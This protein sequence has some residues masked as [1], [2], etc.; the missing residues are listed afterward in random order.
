MDELIE[1]LERWVIGREPAREVGGAR[2][3]PAHSLHDPRV[4]NFDQIVELEPMDSNL[5]GSSVQKIRFSRQH[6]ELLTAMHIQMTHNQVCSVAY[7]FAVQ[8]K[9][10]PHHMNC[11]QV[12]FPKQ[13]CGPTTW[14]VSPEAKAEFIAEANSAQ[15]SPY[16]QTQG[17]SN[18]HLKGK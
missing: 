16:W 10:V 13:T 4:M 18:A 12:V 2:A 1:S 15:S 5:L 17:S 6:L 9:R 3:L 8:E 7:V 11:V 14:H